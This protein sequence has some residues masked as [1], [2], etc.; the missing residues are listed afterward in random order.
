MLGFKSKFNFSAQP[1]VN[2]NEYP[3]F[4]ASALTIHG[5]VTPKVLKNV[6]WVLLY[7]SVVTIVNLWIPHAELPIGPFEYAGFVMALLLV[8][9][10]N[11]GYDRWW[12]ARKIWRDIVNKSRNLTIMLLAY[13]NNH[14]TKNHELELE[15]TIKY[16]A[17]IPYGIKK[18]LRDNKSYDD[19][20]HLLDKQTIEELNTLSILFYVYLL[21][22]QSI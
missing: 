20:H 10:V 1:S 2:K 5:S 13:T 12:E 17:S 9:R 15:K 18:S 14:S 3:S 8:F 7:A 19:L 21:K 22:L 6:F 11:A 16:I 4:I